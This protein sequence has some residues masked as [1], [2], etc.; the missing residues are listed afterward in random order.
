MRIIWI[1]IFLL[2]LVWSGVAP[3]DGITWGLEVFPAL[4]GGLILWF[5]RERFPLTPLCIS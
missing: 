3:A 2:V 5:T 4:V 1:V